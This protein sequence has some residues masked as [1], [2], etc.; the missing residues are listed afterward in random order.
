M[1]VKTDIKP[2]ENV[3]LSSYST[4]RLGGPARYLLEVRD[5]SEI[6]P[7][8]AWAEEQMIDVIMIGVGSNII[9]H[10][11]GFEGLVLVNKIT[12]FELQKQ[13]FSS[14]ATIGA[15]EPW[16]S[17]VAR[18]VAEDLSGVEQLSLIPGLT[19]ATPVQNV[20]A[21]GREISDAL[22][23][24]QA[25]DREEK[26][27]VVIPKSEC[28]FAYRKSRFNTTDKGRFFITSITLTLSPNPPM[29]PFYATLQSYLTQNNIT[30]YTPQTIRDAVIAIRTSKLPDPAKIAN[31]G[32]FFW[33]PIIGYTQLQELR[34][35]YSGIKYWEV[36]D[37]EY[38]ISAAWLL[39]W[40]G[41]KGY[42]EPNTGMAIYDKHS[43]VFV[44][45][46]AKDTAS[47]IAFRDAIKAKV[48]EKFGIE[49]QQE[50]LLLP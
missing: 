4:M 5:P 50:P 42:H 18:T 16:D 34:E 36:G 29:P 28:D 26:K 6:P 8:I 27:M 20:G 48:K 14:F 40:L 17:V 45:E 11:S 2:L 7:A 19:G 47:L 43:L 49:L 21:Y 41:L 35:K 38:K 22:V 32:S 25:Y 9:W 12:G 33:N 3:P 31:C 46:S 44:N 30:T 1:D 37:D 10:D 23:T 13:E 15:G 24:V 39:E